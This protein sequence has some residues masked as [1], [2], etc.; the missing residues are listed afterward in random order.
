MSAETTM[1]LALAVPFAGALAIALLG[2][3][4]HLRETA[5]LVTAGALLGLVV[6]LIPDAQAGPLRVVLF[7]MMPGFPIALHL[8]PLGMVYALVASSLWLANSLYSIG[9]VRANREKHQT[10]FFVCFALAIGSAAG[11]AFAANPLTLFLFYEILTLS[12]Y[13]LV[14]H[15]GNDEAVRAGRTYLGVLLATSIG[16]QLA[17]ILWIQALAAGD[18]VAGTE[19]VM[20]G[21]FAGALATG[22]VSSGLILLLYVMYVYGIGKAAILP[23]H[24]WLPAAMVAPTPVS[25]FLHAVAVV[26]AGVFC[27]LKITLYVFGVETLRGIGGGTWLVYA[28]GATILIASLIALFQDN[29]KRRLAYSTVSQLSYV[30][31]G[32]ALLTPLSI[33]AATLHVAVHA[34]G[35]ITLFFAAGAVY[36]ASHRTK[37]SELD[38]LGRRMPFTMGAFTVATLSLIG[39]PP[40]AGFASKWF[41]VGGAAEALDA[42]APA[43]ALFTLTILALSTLLNAAYFL[44]IVYRAFFRPPPAGSDPHGEAPWTLV[45]PLV[46]TAILTL[47]LFFWPAPILDLARA[48]V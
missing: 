22:A 36:T 30:V 2:R 25:A 12:T 13:P 16:L 6:R 45:V 14:T 44:P 39:I 10:R 15:K 35:K 33:V 7:E 29:L 38:G 42:G 9:Y 40:A 18:A 17:A 20:G 28:A 48:L 8:E 24:R 1:L 23:V 47:A 34:V 5:T 26:K 46:T 21:V 11:I 37:V 3:F 31:I 19:F 4:P 43:E 32:A 27:V 41:L